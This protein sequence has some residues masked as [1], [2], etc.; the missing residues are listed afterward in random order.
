M[1]EFSLAERNTAVD[2]RSIQSAPRD[3]L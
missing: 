3:A 2:R 1:L